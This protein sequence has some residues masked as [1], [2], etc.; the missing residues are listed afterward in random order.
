MNSILNGLIESN[1]IL[2]CTSK[3]NLDT[4]QQPLKL[5]LKSVGGNFNNT[6]KTKEGREGAYSLPWHV[7]LGRP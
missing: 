5:P 3:G 1:K 2:P 4:R 6:A 7:A